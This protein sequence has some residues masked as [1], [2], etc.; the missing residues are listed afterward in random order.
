MVA[1]ADAT[2]GKI[3]EKVDEID[4]RI[5][6][7]GKIRNYVDYVNKTISKRPKCALFLYAQGPAVGK[8]VTVLEVVKRQRPAGLTSSLSV[9]DAVSGPCKRSSGRCV[10]PKDE[11]QS[12]TRARSA[13]GKCGSA[14][15]DQTTRSSDKSTPKASNGVVWMQA[16][17]RANVL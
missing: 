4:V 6:T 8:L 14:A 1:G 3:T 13:I 7:H 2:A 11:S 15:S 12:E 9:G 17:L 16:E 5:T 10:E